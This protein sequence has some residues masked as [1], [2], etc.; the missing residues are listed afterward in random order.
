[1][2]GRLV[3][4][5]DR[6]V[7]EGDKITP[8]NYRKGRFFIFST[9]LFFLL[10]TSG[11]LSVLTLAEDNSLSASTSASIINIC[12]VVALLLMF[13]LYRKLGKRI[14][15]VNLISLFGWL[16]NIGVYD[17]TGGIYS[18]DNLWGIVI[19]AW[20]FLVADKISGIIWFVITF[21]TYVLFLFAEL[22]GWKDF[23]ADAGKLMPD[24]YMINYGLGCVFLAII[25]MIHE[26]NKEK[27]HKELIKAK[28]EIENQKK[29]VDQKNK[30]VTDSINYAGR[31]Q[32]SQMTPEI[33]IEKSLKRLN[34]G[35]KEYPA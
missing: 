13:F 28:S 4:F 18:P 20:I 16:T 3:Q 29:I 2:A 32:R 10:A 14:L 8:D 17:V 27:Y 35:S 1:M 24:Y 25:I 9:A 33:Y 7:Y 19:S 22:S 23:K 15:W 5:A 6:F 21:F 31:I 11:T 26:T 30:D 34:R 12:G